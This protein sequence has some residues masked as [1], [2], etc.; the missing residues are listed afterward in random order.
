MSNAIYAALARQTG[1]MNEMQV[2]ANNLANSS[3]TG[4]KSDRAVFA[5]FVAGTNNNLS[6]LSMGTLAGHTTDLEQGG[7][8]FTN[9]TFDLAVQGE[10]YFLVETPQGQRL[11][12]AGHF[13]LNAESELI[14][15]MGN[16]VLSA[17]GGPVQIPG[18]ATNVSIAGDGTISFDGVIIDQVGVVQPEGQLTRAGG[19]MFAAEEGFQQME[20]PRVVQGALE[21]S[22]VSPVLEVAR[23]IE[24][25]RAYEAG[26]ALIEG[27]DDRIAKFISTLRQL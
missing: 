11:T 25:Q 2:V 19:T 1:L 13:Q 23:M 27:E 4:Y 5:E 18:E 14:D 16:R 12:R 21:Q 22:N 8:R 6:D 24:V 17:G 26:Q 20:E 7:L 15:S 3:T 10:G 9:G